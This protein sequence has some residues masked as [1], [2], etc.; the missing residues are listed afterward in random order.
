MSMQVRIFIFLF[1]IPL[2]LHSQTWTL[3]QDNFESG[4]LDQWD[5]VPSDDPLAQPQ[6]SAGQG[7]SGSVGLEVTVSTSQSYIYKSG[8]VARE[9]GSLSFWFHP[10][11]VNIPDP[12]VWIPDK[13]IRIAAIKGGESWETLAAIR[14]RQVDGEYFGY[15]EWCDAIE[16]TQRDFVNG[17]FPLANNWQ[18]IV[19]EIDIDNAIRIYIND[20]LTREITGV[21]HCHTNL[22]I[23]KVGKLNSNSTIIPSGTVLYDQVSYTVPGISNLY[24][25]QA[26]GD[27]SNDGRTPVSAFATIQSAAELA[28]PGTVVHVAE[29]VYSEIVRPV[30]GG[31][32]GLFVT[33]Q[34]EPAP[35][36]SVIID[37]TGFDLGAW[38]G[39]FDIE[40]VDY[41]RVNG[42]HIKH[43]T[44][45]GIQ[46]YNANHIEI[47][48]CSTYDTKS[49]GIY[50]RLGEDVLIKRNDIRKAVNGGSQECLVVAECN[51]FQVCYNKIHDGV[52]L[53]TG[54]EGINI[55]AGCYDGTVHHNHVFDLPKNY[56]PDIHEDGE[57]GIYLGPYNQPPPNHLYDIQVYQNIVSTPFGIG[58]GAEEGG[59]I[60]NIY[61]HNNI[62]YNCYYRG[63]TITN[64]V[65]PNAGPKKHIYI[66]NN[67]ICRC[68][69][70]TDGWPDGG[71]IYIESVVPEDEDFQVRNNLLSRNIGYQIK[72]RPGALDNLVTEY[73]LID[74]M[75]GNDAHEITGDFPIFGD[76]HFVDFDNNN[77]ALLAT[78]PTI[79]AGS[80]T[81][82]PAFDFIDTPR[83]LDGDRQGSFEI[84]IGAH[85]FDPNTVFYFKCKCLLEGPYASSTGKMN[86]T[87]VFGPVP[88]QSPYPTD[89]RMIS[90]LP[91]EAI[92]W[93]VLGFLSPIQQNVV[94][95]SSLFLRNDGWIIDEHGNT[96]IAMTGIDAGDYELLIVHRNHL[97]IKSATP[98]QFSAGQTTLYDFTTSSSQYALSKSAKQV[99]TNTWAM[100]AGDCNQDGY[101]TTTDYVLWYNQQQTGSTGYLTNDLDFNGLVNFDD[102]A[103]WLE[104]SR[105]H[106]FNH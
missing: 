3:L 33:Y 93:I 73:N 97:T 68:G 22:S 63:I 25:N 83:P 21:Q 74:D 18:K 88:N 67:T 102:Y 80:P 30:L 71:G 103:I 4:N 28:G 10:S 81:L 46:C 72:A 11:N 43:S 54:G 32:T 24:V 84:D 47:L 26:T 31:E 98:Q 12:D 19:L 94:K 48:N 45:A 39:M 57:V 58:I 82:A 75:V 78:S 60:E 76:P 96:E 23:V 90:S 1:L 64:W 20:T 44:W 77:F 6:L 55:K 7:V 16:G 17:Q 34:A 79:D 70:I 87:G 13:T 56:D 51:D 105:Q 5:K 89:P 41:I 85:E 69:N 61:V 15:L 38:G 95:D 66:V 2:L 40:H 29:G 99:D 92:D 8:L 27:D 86:A 53:D 106:F 59:T 101:I 52:G 62:V 42:F 35:G 91:S 100:L 104:N 37:G 65:Y 50:M 49:S 36:D 9:Q 14:M